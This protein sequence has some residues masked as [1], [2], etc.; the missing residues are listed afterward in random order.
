M[1]TC[2]LTERQCPYAENQGAALIYC[3]AYDCRTED[4][5]YCLELDIDLDKPLVGEGWCVVY[6][7]ACEHSRGHG[8]D[9]NVNCDGD[10]E[11]V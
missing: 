6:K 9:G 11:E 4:V 10:C 5:D 2:P 3:A 1:I 7:K 8:E